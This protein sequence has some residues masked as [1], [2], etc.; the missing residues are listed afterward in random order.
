MLL[1]YFFKLLIAHA[2]TDFSLQSEMMNKYKAIV[3]DEEKFVV[4]NWI[5]WLL[6]HSLVN[7]GG[8]WLVTGNYIYGFIEFIVHFFV[9][10]MKVKNVI[11]P[12]VDQIIHIF[13]KVGIV[14]LFHYNIFMVN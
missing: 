1:V 12:D 9:D 7:A 14:L 3:T 6:A 5:H 4:A 10:L 2:F 11:S 8:V 13:T